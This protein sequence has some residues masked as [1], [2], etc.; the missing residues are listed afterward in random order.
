VI[1]ENDKRTTTPAGAEGRI[2][3]AMIS[4]SDKS[5][6]LPFAR[7]LAAFGVEIISTGGTAQL[8]KDAGV[9]VVQ[10]SEFTGFPEMLDGRVKT[11]HP[12]VHGGLLFLRDNPIHQKAMEAQSFVPIDLVVVNLYPFEETI[13]R[14]GVS[15]A[16]AIEK[17]DVGGPSMLR[18]AAKNFRWVTVASRP[19]HYETIVGEMEKLGGRTSLELRERLAAEVFRLT[20]EYDRAIG[21]YLAR[22]SGGTAEGEAAAPGLPEKFPPFQKASDL[23]YGENPHQRGAI[24]TLPGGFDAAFQRLHGREISYNNV[25]DVVA[26]EALVEEFPAE[27]AAAIAIV[28]HNNPC[29][30]G[31]GGTVAEAWAKALATDRDAASGGIVASNRPIDLAAARAID[32]IFTEVV[33]APDYDRDA[34]DLLFGKKNRI[35][36]HRKRRV[37]DLHLLLGF[38][39]RSIPGGLLAQEPDLVDLDPAALRVVTRKQPGESEMTALRFAWKVAKHVKSN[40]IVL[41]AADRTLGIGA[42]QM[43]RVDAARV[44]V[45]KA[46]RAGLDLRGSVVASDAFFP[47]AD[48]LATVADAGAIAAIQPGGSKRDPEVIALAD[49]RGLAMVFTGIRHFRH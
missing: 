46:G 48:G 27:R 30:V 47:F 20:S 38:E 16:E 25:L 18:G 26:A 5:G 13:R 24:Y 10:V 15:R 4:L 35:I 29:G 6:I 22:T 2:R 28:K 40:A 33:I 23:R 34:L 11:L 44:A 42:G 31:L 21:E 49:E 39:V 8:L 1:E 41:A 7:R 36:I 45:E 3:R 37:A 43:S 14:T 12:K 9:E 19:E 17:I 32:S